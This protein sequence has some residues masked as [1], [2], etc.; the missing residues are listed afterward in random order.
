[1]FSYVCH[2]ICVFVLIGI[3]Y[4]FLKNLYTQNQKVFFPKKYEKFITKENPLDDTTEEEQEDTKIMPSS[5]S[6]DRLDSIL[7]DILLDVD[8]K[9]NIF[10][11]LL[12]QNSKE[13]ASKQK[14]FLMTI[15]RIYKT[16]NEEKQKRI[17][18]ILQDDIIKTY[19]YDYKVHIACATNLSMCTEQKVEGTCGS[20]LANMAELLESKQELEKYKTV[21]NDIKSILNEVE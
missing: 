13:D 14:M 19:T 21:I 18:S 5:N 3:I 2:A 9:K 4:L 17:D 15:N 20:L 7:T 8:N 6:Q 1:M 12:K 11:M 16:L 10:A